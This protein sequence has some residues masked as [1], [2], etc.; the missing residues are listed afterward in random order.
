MRR[1]GQQFIKGRYKTTRGIDPKDW[2]TEELN[3]SRFVD[4]LAGL[5][6]EHRGSLRD[7]DGDRQFSQPLL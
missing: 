7:V 5:C 3:W 2:L 1:P 6:E 4:A